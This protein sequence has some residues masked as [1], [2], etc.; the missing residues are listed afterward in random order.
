MP[1]ATAG[2]TSPTFFSFPACSLVGSRG[3]SLPARPLTI[4]T[5]EIP[6]VTPGAPVNRTLQS[7][8]SVG[9][10]L[11]TVVSGQLPPGVNLSPTGTLAGTPTTPGNYVFTVRCTD[12]NGRSDEQTLSMQIDPAASKVVLPVTVPS[13]PVGV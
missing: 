1:T 4:T 10:L 6:P 3:S 5:A 8:A 13:V 12:A 2:G 9:T 7:V 11:C